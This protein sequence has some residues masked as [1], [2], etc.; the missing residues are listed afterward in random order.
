MLS[1]KLRQ[2]AGSHVVSFCLAAKQFF[3]RRLR[4][5]CGERCPGDGLQSSSM[6]IGLRYEIS[7]HLIAS[8]RAPWTAD[9]SKSEPGRNETHMRRWRETVADWITK[10]RRKSLLETFLVE[11]LNEV[12]I[13]NEL[14]QH[15]RQIEEDSSQVLWSRPCCTERAIALQE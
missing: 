6:A 2:H 12:Y 1:G 14:Q 3:A 11:T 9:I 10:S 5:P 8:H 4:V 13:R 7:T 15:C